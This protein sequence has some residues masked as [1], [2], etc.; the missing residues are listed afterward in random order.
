MP[1]RLDRLERGPQAGL[2][3]VERAIGD[4]LK[5]TKVVDGTV[6][7]TF[8]VG[9]DAD[10]V[11][12]TVIAGRPDTVIARS[13]ARSQAGALNACIAAAE[14]FPY[15]AFLED[16][17]RWEPHHLACALSVLQDHGFVSTT[18]L[19][20]NEND[21]ILRIND[22]PNPSGW[23]MPAQTLQQVGPFDLAMRWHLDNEWL[24]R[25]AATGI[26]RCHLVERSAPIALAHAAQVRPW[27]ANVIRYGGP[28]MTLRRHT[29]FKPLVVRLIHSRSGMARIAAE[30]A[31]KR[32]SRDEYAVLMKRYGH[33]PF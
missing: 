19:E 3:F 8:I 12:P 2:T 20:V 25:L 16:D 21:Q 14:G 13:A 28:R 26:P 23:V 7:L 5:Q 32:Q 33:V 22:F 4:A 31:L 15:V 17:D 1:S 10:A 11:V 24:G 30:P 18:Q 29:S 9:V 6:A 27:I